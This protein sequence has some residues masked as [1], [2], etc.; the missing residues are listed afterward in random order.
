MRKFSN[1]QS[2]IKYLRFGRLKTLGKPRDGYRIFMEDDNYNFYE[3]ILDFNIVETIAREWLAN[4][5]PHDWK[6][7]K[8]SESKKQKGPESALTNQ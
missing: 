5:V 3:V 1:N 8:E 6:Q 7:I 4:D 2:V